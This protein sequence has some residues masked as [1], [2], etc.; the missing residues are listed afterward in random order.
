MLD[1]RHCAVISRF[2]LVAIEVMLALPTVYTPLER[3]QMACPS[4][5]GEWYK[6]MLSTG[7]QIDS[8]IHPNLLPLSAWN[9][10]VT[11]VVISFDSER[12]SRCCAFVFYS[13]F[14]PHRMLKPTHPHYTSPFPITPRPKSVNH[15]VCSCAW[16]SL[17]HLFFFICPHIPVHYKQVNINIQAT[18]RSPKTY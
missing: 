12:R 1:S 17:V 4:R 6:C 16:V 15:D 13:V 9:E 14:L 8:P 7:S 18:L 11:A 5:C 2:L 10:C 3:E